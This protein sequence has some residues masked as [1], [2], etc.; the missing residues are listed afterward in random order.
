MIII[1]AVD[2][3]NGK[4]VRLI[5]GRMEDETVFSNDPA[6]MAQ[7]WAH[8]GAELIHVVDLDGAFEKSPQNIDA[9]KNIIKT[10]DTPIQLGGGIRNERTVKTLL[11]MGVQRVI[12][13]TEAIK[14]PEWVMQTARHFPGQV[15]VGI[16]ARNGRVAIEGWTETTDTR[17]I[18]LA[19]RFEDCG[20]AAINFTDIYRDG[21]Q[22]GPN[23]TETGRLA[24]AISIPVVASGGVATIEDIKNLLPLETVGVTGVI[25]GKALYSGTLDFKQAL[26]LVQSA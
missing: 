23:I 13:G 7:K 22:T 26:A 19:Q 11:D 2:I 14:N 1:P 15:V 9:V 12:I 17:A 6:A 21:M 24:K 25:T 5:Q 16:D 4:C 8:A 10:V 20:V 3:K 18:D